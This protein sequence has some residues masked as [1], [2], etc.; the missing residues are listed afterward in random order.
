M[1]KNTIVLLCFLCF[2]F[3]AIAQSELLINQKQNLQKRLFLS[4]IK[5][6]TFTSTDFELNLEDNPAQSLLINDIYNFRVET[7]S[8]VSNIIDTQTNSIISVSLFPNPASDLLTLNFVLKG[9]EN[10]DIEL[11][12]LSGTSLIAIQDEGHTGLNSLSIPL[13]K[14]QIAGVYFVKIKT[15]DVLETLKLIKY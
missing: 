12:N 6:I 5:S 10:V 2:H 4:E 13:N 8:V 1:K 15:K 7:N 11:F 3:A 9:N 14:L